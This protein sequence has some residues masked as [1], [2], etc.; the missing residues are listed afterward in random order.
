MI[1]QCHGN[2]NQKYKNLYEKICTQYPYYRRRM[3]ESHV[4]P[5][6]LR[7]KIISYGIMLQF[8]AKISML[9]NPDKPLLI[10]QLLILYLKSC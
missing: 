4:K 5:Q 2:T 1:N 10:G 7:T 8:P 6:K 9:I 3:Y